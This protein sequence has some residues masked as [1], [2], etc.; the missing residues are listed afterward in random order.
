MYNIVFPVVNIMSSWGEEWV[1]C[2][3]KFLVELGTR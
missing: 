3:Q 1:V 2:T